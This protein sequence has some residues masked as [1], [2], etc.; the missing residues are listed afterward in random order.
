MKVFSV[1]FAKG[2]VSQ[3]QRGWVCRVWFKV[4]TVNQFTEETHLAFA[5][6]RWAFWAF[7]KAYWFAIRL[8]ATLAASKAERSAVGWGG[9]V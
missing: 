5:S 7:L 1:D 4:E 2:N 8:H 6:S 3:N 9:G